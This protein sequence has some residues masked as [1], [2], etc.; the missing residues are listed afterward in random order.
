VVVAVVE[1]GYVCDVYAL[2]GE[3]RVDGTV[4]AVY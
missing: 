1:F 3:E 4:V 2:W